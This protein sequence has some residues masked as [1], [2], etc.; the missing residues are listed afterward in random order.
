MRSALIATMIAALT[1]P[2]YAQQRSAKE[3]ES[4]FPQRDADIAVKKERAKETDQGY[5]AA[6][7]NIPDK[8]QPNDPWKNVR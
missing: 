2:A 3:P 7:K 4:G 6:I 8:K 5:K 1:I